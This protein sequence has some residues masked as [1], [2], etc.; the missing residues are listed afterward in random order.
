MRL[1]LHACNLL[2]LFDPNDKHI[3]VRLPE[4]DFLCAVKVDHVNPMKQTPDYCEYRI[5]T[6]R[7]FVVQKMN[8]NIVSLATY[9]AEQELYIEVNT[10]TWEV[11][12]C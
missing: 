3:T 7:R 11:T 5:S 4:G 10:E 9:A 12:V 6:G 2:F 1:Q 8:D